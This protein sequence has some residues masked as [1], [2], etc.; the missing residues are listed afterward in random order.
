MKENVAIVII[1]C[2]CV[3]FILPIL[4]DFTPDNKPDY[5][6]RFVKLL[7]IVTVVLSFPNL[8]NLSK[9]DF[10][11]ELTPE[12]HCEGGPYMWS[13]SPEKQKFC[14]QFSKDDMARY[15]CPNGFVGAPIWRGGVG[16]QPPESNDQWKNTRCSSI[17]DDYKDPQVL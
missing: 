3:V 7:L 16:N 8:L 15:E 6:M 2:V 10:L 12:K 9:D 17:R 13:S 11:F 14:S 1:L 4:P 5:L